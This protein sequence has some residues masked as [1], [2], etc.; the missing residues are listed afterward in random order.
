VKSSL[1][2]IWEEPPTLKGYGSKFDNIVNALLEN[3]GQWI[4]L[5]QPSKNSN[6]G[7]RQVVSRRGLPIKIVTRLRPDG[8]FDIYAVCT[9]GIAQTA[10]PEVPE[11]KESNV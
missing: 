3:P 2:V 4:R 9:T 7:L 10:L 6:T 11:Q 8:A 5:P 1:E